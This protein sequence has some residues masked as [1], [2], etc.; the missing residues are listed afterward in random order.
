[1]RAI[2]ILVWL[3]ASGCDNTLFGVPIGGEQ[4]PV[5]PEYQVSFAGVQ[6]M[7]E[8]HCQVCHPTVD[9]FVMDDLV[10]DLEAETGIYIVPGSPE[11]SMYWRLISATR[12]DGDPRVMPDGTPTGL[13]PAE[14]EHVRLWI[15]DGAPLDEAHDSG[16]GE[17][18]DEGTETTSDQEG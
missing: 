14:R 15:L 12:I 11:D 2:W 6:A 13:R 9:P 3:G 16:T 17:G 10:E 18:S 8:D 7:W 5:D 4:G 1:M